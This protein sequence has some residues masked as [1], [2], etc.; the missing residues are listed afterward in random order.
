MTYSKV[1]WYIA[2]ISLLLLLLLFT[3]TQQTVTPVAQGAAFIAMATLGIFHGANDLL[4]YRRSTQQNVSAL[5]FILLYVLFAC[6]IGVVVYLEPVL[7][8]NLFVLLSAFHFG[9]EHF[10]WWKEQKN[11]AF[12]LWCFFYGLSVF[13][14]LFLTHLS[15]LEQFLEAS[16]Y[17]PGVL[18]WSTFFMIPIVVVQVVLGLAHLFLGKASLLQFLF[19]ELSLV[20]LYFI[21]EQLD[22][23]S[24]F[25]FY[26][27]LWHSIPSIFS[28]IKVLGLS[29][30]KGFIAYSKHAMPFYLTS[31]FGLFILYYFMGIALLSLTTIVLLG[32]MTTIPHVILFAYL[33]VTVQP[34]N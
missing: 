12:I 13:S 21:F 4:I 5:L 8:I 29:G 34:K 22:L 3:T 15:T 9:E 32:A 33:K 19:L 24:S 16:D 2:G 10:S 7:G 17:A 28:Q 23:F 27:V 14:L 26:F 6:V 25:A 20:L 1:Y 11:V 30:W 18:T 31:I